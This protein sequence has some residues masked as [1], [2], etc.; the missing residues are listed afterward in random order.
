M[1]GLPFDSRDNDDDKQSQLPLCLHLP[2]F[3]FRPPNSLCSPS[4]SRSG[5][6]AKL[7]LHTKLTPTL[8]ALRLPQPL[9]GMFLPQTSR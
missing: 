9:L 2:S 4:A 3:C 7:L 1:P 5:L 6:L 8:V